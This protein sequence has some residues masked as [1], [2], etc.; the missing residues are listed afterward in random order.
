MYNYKSR[1]QKYE[2][3]TTHSIDNRVISN[4]NA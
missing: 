4:R 3:K 1:G 2:T